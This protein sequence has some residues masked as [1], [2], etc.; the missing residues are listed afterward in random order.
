VRRGALLL[1]AL[2]AL[3]GCLRE[4]GA[5]TLS[6]KT[7]HGEMA[8]EGALVTARPSDDPSAPPAA[9]V[10]SGYHGSWRLELP[11]GRYDLCAAFELPRGRGTLPVAGCLREVEVPPGTARIDRLLLTLHRTP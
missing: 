8:L 3:G 6:G 2:F 11:P 4:P 1:L 9:R 5:T 7:V 10:R